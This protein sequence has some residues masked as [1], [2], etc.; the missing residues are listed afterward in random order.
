MNRDLISP[1]LIGVLIVAVLGI[2]IAAAIGAPAVQA[3]NDDSAFAQQD[4]SALAQQDGVSDCSRCHEGTKGS[5]L[6]PT[7]CGECHT[8]MYESWQESGHADSLS[9]GETKTQI[10]Y[11]EECARCHIESEIKSREDIDFATTGIEVGKTDEPVT[12]E[13]CHAPPEQGWFQHFAKGGDML[14]PNGTGPHGSEDAQVSTPGEVCTACHSNN[15]VLGLANESKISPHSATLVGSVD[16]G[17]SGDSHPNTTTSPTTTSPPT[18]TA[19]PGFGI[20]AALLALVGA[21]LVVRRR[22]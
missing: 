2:T 6:N 4:D 12:C 13:V 16:G 15:V 14:A 8:D 5:G 19:V 22:R 21:T 10:K 7:M 11:Q 1:R 3:T 9:T 20:V 17:S 18:E